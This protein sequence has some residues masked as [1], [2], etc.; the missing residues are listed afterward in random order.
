[1]K[2]ATS[3]FRPHP[4]IIFLES[5]EDRRIPDPNPQLV[6]FQ[7]HIVRIVKGDDGVVSDVW[8][9]IVTISARPP[10]GIEKLHPTANVLVVCDYGKHDLHL[11]EDWKQFGLLRAG[12][13]T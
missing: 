10:M 11:G 12:L 5:K 3:K 9:R 4:N 7:C 8:G 2:L 6:E 13:D 1:M